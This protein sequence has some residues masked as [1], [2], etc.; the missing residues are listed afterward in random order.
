[1]NNRKKASLANRVLTLADKAR[2]LYQKKDDAFEQLVKACV[3]GEVI[4][5]K[6]G[7]F[8]IVDNFAA[9]NV[10][11]RPAS[12]HRYELKEVRVPKGEKKLVVAK[13]EGVEETPAGVA[14]PEAVV[15]VS[16]AP[17]AV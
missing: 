2:V 13:V 16:A 10:G 9:R 11:F 15:V 5:T 12:F 3:I 7:R 14:A 6:S 4:E 17:A 8:E 1:M